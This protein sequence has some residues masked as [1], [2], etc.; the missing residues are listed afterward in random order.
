[1]TTSATSAFHAAVLAPSGEDAVGAIRRDF[2]ILNRLIDGKPLIYMDSAATSL[3]PVQVA[4]AVLETYNHCTSNIHRGRH[5]LSEE[6]SDRYE[7]A[8]YK[9]AIAMGCSADEVVFVRN[10]TEGL[11]V[12]AEILRLGRDDLV[13]GFLDSHHS[14]MLPWRR[15]CRFEMVATGRDGLPDLD[16]L[17]TLLK[18]RPKAVVVTH[19]SNVTGAYAPVDEIVALA[20]AAGALIILDAAQS[21]PHVPIN[22]RSLDVDFLAFSSHKMLGPSGI[23]CLI[24]RSEL[25]NDQAPVYIGGGTVDEVRADGWTLRRSPHRHEAGTPAIEAAIGLGAAIDYLDGIGFDAVAA[26]ERQLS[27]AL[28]DEIGRRPHFRLIGPPHAD[29]RAPLVSFSIAG[30]EDLRDLSRA[31]SDGYGIM[32]RSGH[33]CCQPLVDSHS[34][35]E[36]LRVSAY[37]YNTQDEVE[38]VFAALDALVPAFSR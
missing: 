37:L 33:L 20:R 1:M 36:V 11:N 27:K 28:I 34:D 38:R 29:Q 26:H 19:C 10:T 32:C 3:K 30:C 8:R 23:G 22:F 15:S 24:G 13:V 2:P 4:E 9:I 12:A 6:A 5:L 17:R 7:E 16:Q 21:A 25:L 31:L 35:A 18:Q 14:Q